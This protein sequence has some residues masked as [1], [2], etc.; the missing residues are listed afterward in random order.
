MDKQTGKVDSK[1]TESVI[2]I[3]KAVLMESPPPANMISERKEASSD[4]DDEINDA[5]ADAGAGA[6]A[7]ADAV[8]DNSSGE[9]NFAAS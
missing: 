7:G 3:P 9:D 8:E 5:D 6:G 1:D 4:N 2:V